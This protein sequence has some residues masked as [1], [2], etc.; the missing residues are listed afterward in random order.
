[1]SD[2]LVHEFEACLEAGNGFGSSGPLVLHIIEP[3]SPGGGACTLHLLADLIRT[4]RGVDHRVCIIG[5]GRQIDLSR[6]CGVSPDGWM[7]PIHRLPFAGVRDWRR[8]V[9]AIEASVGRVNLIHAWTARSS[10]LARLGTPRIPHLT[11]LH[12]G[13]MPGFTSRYWRRCLDRRPA[14][15][16]AA[17]A[18][19][20][21]DCRRIGVR[22]TNISLM[23]PAIDANAIDLAD[24]NSVRSRWQREHDVPPQAFVVGLIAEPISWPDILT[25]ATTIGR[26]NLS[27]R[28][29]KLLVHERAMHRVEAE[30]FLQH[31]RLG[32]ILI[33]DDDA[34]EPWRIVSGLDAALWPG[35][36]RQRPSPSIL[37]M[38][39]AM[40]ARIPVIAECTDDAKQLI[41]DGVNGFLIDPHD[42]N[43]ASRQ[44]LRIFDDAPL[45][46]SM[47][48]AASA[49]VREFYEMSAYAMR[50]KHAYELLLAERAH[51]YPT[52]RPY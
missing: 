49:H 10:I 1:M 51:S 7:C 27:G 31:L 25:A 15:V 8:Y 42:V 18:A 36:R 30:R 40:A 19:I 23:P 52:S 46:R 39:W 16:L 33:V 48:D 12:V 6:R 4:L 24:R 50:M 44:V 41:D 21:R 35:P 38:L 47:G 37:P 43:A 29:V 2:L 9:Q 5:N 26:V 22:S 20:A 14:P 11:S 3:G 28:P 17:S 32:E 13:P 34:A 45:L